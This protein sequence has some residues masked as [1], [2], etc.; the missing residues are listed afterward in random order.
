MS[1]YSV[2]P[3]NTRPDPGNSD[4]TI[5]RTF[6]VWQ[7]PNGATG[8]R[9]RFGNNPVRGVELEREFG[10]AALIALYT[11][12]QSAKSHADELNNGMA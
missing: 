3:A 2:S 8:K 10:S 4:W 7:L 9:N 12:R 1:D 11:N 6:G 5:P